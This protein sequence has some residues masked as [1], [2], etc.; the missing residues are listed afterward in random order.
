[1]AMER[2]AGFKKRG[3]VEQSK[4]ERVCGERQRHCVLDSIVMRHGSN[5]TTSSRMKSQRPEL[6]VAPSVC[7]KLT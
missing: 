7:D 2:I 4:V 3:G 1:M 5:R 6:G